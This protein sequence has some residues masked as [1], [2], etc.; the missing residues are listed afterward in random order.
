[1]IDILTSNSF[2]A[3]FYARLQRP[4]QSGDEMTIVTAPELEYYCADLLESA[5][6][7]IIPL[8]PAGQEKA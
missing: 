1:M 3:L 6:N 5:P 8:E 2:S 7:P 4:Q